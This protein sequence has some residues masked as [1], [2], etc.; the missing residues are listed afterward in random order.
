MHRFLGNEIAATDGTNLVDFFVSQ[1]S[2]SFAFELHGWNQVFFRVSFNCS[3]FNRFSAY[4][5]W[6]QLSSYACCV[7]AVCYAAVFIGPSAPDLVSLVD[8]SSFNAFKQMTFGGT[9]F[10]FNQYVPRPSYEQKFFAVYVI[11][12]KYASPTERYKFFV[13]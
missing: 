5:A 11:S 4:T 9:I 1:F 12:A 7:A 2:Q 6:Q 3:A 8:Y 10:C 13:F